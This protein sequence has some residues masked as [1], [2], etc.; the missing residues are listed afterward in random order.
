MVLQAPGPPAS[1]FELRL[2]IQLPFAGLCC[3][4]PGP[5]NDIRRR[6]PHPCVRACV[7]VGGRRPS[8]SRWPRRRTCLAFAPVLCVVAYPVRLLGGAGPTSTFELLV[9]RPHLAREPRSRAPSGQHGL[10]QS[11]ALWPSRSRC[12]SG[13]ARGDILRDTGLLLKVEVRLPGGAPLWSAGRACVAR[14]PGRRP[15]PGRRS[16]QGLSSRVRQAMGAANPW[17]AVGLPAWLKTGL[18]FLGWFPRFLSH[19]P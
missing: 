19:P 5:L 8:L 15:F 12:P 10:H 13:R 3:C 16:Q 4:A 7:V 1:I 18:P 11:G 6:Q 2:G 9:W 17:L 14:W